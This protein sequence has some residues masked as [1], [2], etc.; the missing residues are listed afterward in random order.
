MSDGMVTNVFDRYRIRLC[1]REGKY[2]MPIPH[3]AWHLPRG[4]MNDDIR[5][6]IDSL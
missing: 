4:E 5:S 6:T 3:G 2:G 1:P